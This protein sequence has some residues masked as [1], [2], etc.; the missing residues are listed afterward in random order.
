MRFRRPRIRSILVG[1]ALL[2]TA[3][4]Q[5]SVPA[6][7]A[8]NLVPN[9][10]LET[11]AG[12]LP[13]CWAV[14]AT[15]RN[16]G[17]AKVVA[18]RVSK[19]AVQIKQT[20]RVTGARAL[21][22]TKACAIRKVK[23]GQRLSLSFY[24]KATTAK[25]SVQFYRQKADGA[26]TKWAEYGAGGKN[27]AWHKRSVKT[28][29]VPAGTRAVRFGVAISGKGAITTD[30]YVLT[31]AAGASATCT[32]EVGC[33]EGEWKVRDFG[34]ALPEE[35]NADYGDGADVRE[36]KGVRAMHTV[37]LK[38][39]KVLLIA[40]S[41]NNKEL[42]QAGYFKSMVY[43]PKNGKYT[44]IDTPNDMFCAGHVQLSDG[45][46][47]VLGG[48]LKYADNGGAY[49]GWQGDDKSYVFDPATNK[50]TQV[51]TAMS[52]GHWYPS[53]T[54]L[55]NGDVYSVGGYAKNYNAEQ[56]QVVS[57]VAELFKYSKKSP[58]GGAW[59]PKNKVPQTGINWATYPS[60]ILMQNGRLF[61]TGSSVFGHPVGK[62]DQSNYGQN[63][64]AFL[65]PGV[66]DHTKTDDFR[67]VGGL[68]EKFARDQAASV[69]LP[70]AQRQKVMIMGG[71]DFDEKPSEAHAHTD[72]VDL[73]K[74]TPAYKP[75]PDLNAA[76]AYVSAVLLPDG[77][78]FET[79]GSVGDRAGYVY[80]AAVFD[81][82]KP[83]EW[84][85]MAPDPVGR[86]YHATAVL[87]PDGRVLTAGSNPANSFYETRLSVYSPPYLFKG[88]RPKI[89]GLDSKNWA[90]GS[91]HTFKTSRQIA[92]AWLIRP[93]AVT[94]SSDP[95][96]RAVAPQ[97]LTVTGN[98]VKFKLTNNP[99]VAPPG[100][101]MLFA[102]DANGVP[103]VAKWVH[104][105]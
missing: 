63:D 20:M 22:Q 33:A 23:P 28:A 65:G 62:S 72:I 105:G 58:Y 92:S 3:V 19:R 46:V 21:V 96:Q 54:V 97:K 40:G 35:V 86:T 59:Q 78:V 27:A 100:Y 99:N 102:T 66:L 80:E 76:K 34:D 68:T 91:T 1:S 103:S 6:H 24:L 30:D 5:G 56:N 55:G 75:G 12:K 57:R 4:V 42:F 60:L 52:D 41:G 89:S 8:P 82:K 50:Y 7:A 18:G 47:L 49:L 31:A 2:T 45:R 51:K 17:S 16:E 39:G 44:K 26:W 73:N 43:N 87:L 32:D 104:I 79:G 38:N 94:H 11:P 70:P 74:A 77:T 98:S 36:K 14:E 48:T 84:T 71:M 9:P 64:N 85:A 67:P 10:K 69:L 81:P 95:N 37:L 53:A 101:Y 29:P 25:I 93:I 15:G 90:Y 83:N 13:K 88:P 61:Y